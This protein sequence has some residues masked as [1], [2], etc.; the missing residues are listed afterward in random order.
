MEKKLSIVIPVYNRGGIIGRTLQSIQAQTY[1]PLKIILVDNASTD[2]TV[3]VLGAWRSEVSAPDF[4]VEVLCEPT[5]GAA[6][7]RNRGLSRVDTPWVMFFD[8]D[9]TMR[10]GHCDRAMAAAGDDVDIVG[11]DVNIT[12][13][14]GCRTGIFVRDHIHFDNIFHGGFATLRWCARAEVVRRAGGWIPETLI[15]DDIELGTR[16]IAGGVRIKRLKGEPTVDVEFSSVSIS[17]EP[18]LSRLE[19]IDAVLGLIKAALPEDKKH[20]AAFKL[21]LAAGEAMRMSRDAEVLGKAKALY[22]KALS[23]TE[24]RFERAVM[25]LV[26]NYIR[27]FSRGSVALLSLFLK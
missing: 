15:W 27:R 14:G 19:R 23:D 12:Q 24:N 2:N 20:Y 8:S 3:A 25:C 7:A 17:N 10:P 1:R 13:P 6:V 4:E 26:F 16:M 11:W 21:A 9:D 22:N 18:W 5:P